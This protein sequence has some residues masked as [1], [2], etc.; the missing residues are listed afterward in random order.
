MQANLPKDV[1]DSRV[2]RNE[3]AMTFDNDE[4]NKEDR[5][6]DHLCGI[7]VIRVTMRSSKIANYLYSTATCDFRKPQ[8]IFKRERPW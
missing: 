8:S 5:G 3:D 6:K 2:N 4:S 1:Q 7:R